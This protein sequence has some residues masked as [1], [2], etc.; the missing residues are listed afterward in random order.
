VRTGK[1]IYTYNKVGEE[2]EIIPDRYEGDFYKNKKHGIGH[3]TYTK[4]KE[5]YYGSF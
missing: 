2:D 3:M 1:G 4:R 5:T